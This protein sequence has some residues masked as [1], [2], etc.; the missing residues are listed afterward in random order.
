MKSIFFF[1]QRCGEISF[2]S[3]D[4]NA[5]CVRMLGKGKNLFPFLFKCV[6]MEMCLIGNFL[7][8]H[9]NDHDDPQWHLHSSSTCSPHEYILCNE[10][11]I[12]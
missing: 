1:P 6:D 12:I 9:D 11:S 5:K 2:D 3:P 10:L 7:K 4:Q 8:V